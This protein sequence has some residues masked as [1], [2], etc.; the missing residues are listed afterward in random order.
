MKAVL[1]RRDEPDVGQL[2]PVIVTILF[3]SGD[4]DSSVASS[5][6]QSGRANDSISFAAR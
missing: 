2:A 6:R 5:N 3:Q 4:M 1:G